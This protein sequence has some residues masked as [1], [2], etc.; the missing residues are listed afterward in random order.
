MIC[1]FFEFFNFTEKKNWCKIDLKSE[2][3]KFFV[4]KPKPVSAGLLDLGE[5]IEFLQEYQLAAEGDGQ[6][7]LTQ[8]HITFGEG[9]K[10]MLSL[11]V[12]RR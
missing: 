6:D 9:Y 11:A 4:E 10:K 8:V 7:W 12:E 5:V 1:R 2:I 3:C